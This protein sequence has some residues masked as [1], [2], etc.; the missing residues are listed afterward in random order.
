MFFGE[1]SFFFFPFMLRSSFLL[2]RC[3]RIFFFFPWTGRD[4][5][6]FRINRTSVGPIFLPFLATPFFWVGTPGGPPFHTISYLFGQVPG[7]GCGWASSLCTFIG[8]C[9]AYFGSMFGP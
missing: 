1:I 8:F 5:D 3:P 9:T 6:D 7:S 2:R 4:L